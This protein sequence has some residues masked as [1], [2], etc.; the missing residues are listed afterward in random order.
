VH[1]RTDFPKKDNEN[2][3]CHVDLRRGKDG[4]ITASKRSLIRNLPSGGAL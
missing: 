1:L 3:L 4:E 2:W